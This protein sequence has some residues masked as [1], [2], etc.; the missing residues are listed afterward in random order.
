MSYDGHL[1]MGLNCDSGAVD[2]PE[3]LRDLIA[4]EYDALLEAGQPKPARKPAKKKPAKK[5][6]PRTAKSEAEARSSR[7]PSAMG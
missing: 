6:A 1:D 7:P 2:D 5:A 3:L 4:A